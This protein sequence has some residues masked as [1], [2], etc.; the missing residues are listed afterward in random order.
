MKL[1]EQTSRQIERALRKVSSKFSPDAECLPLT[2]LYIQVKQE[3]GELL[4]FDDNDTELTRCVVE[5]WI[6]NSDEAFYDE[7]PEALTALL[8]DLHELVENIAVLRPYSIVLVGEDKETLA[9]LYLVDDD[10]IVLS[11]DLMEGLDEDLDSFW[12]SLSGKE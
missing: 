1:S 6:G 7:L 4:V 5:E 3:S 12:E 11:G 10:T 9:D 8:H 2:D